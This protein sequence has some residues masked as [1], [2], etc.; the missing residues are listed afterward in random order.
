[1]L[2]PQALFAVTEIFPLLAPTVAV[3]DIEVELPVQ[4]AGN[5]QV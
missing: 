1:V 4:P 5:V 2:V 3:M